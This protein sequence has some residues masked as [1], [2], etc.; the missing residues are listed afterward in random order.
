MRTLLD[1]IPPHLLDEALE[2]LTPRTA[3]L[4]DSE[5]LEE[6][7]EIMVICIVI[8]LKRYHCGGLEIEGLS[9]ETFNIGMEL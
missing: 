1:E 5:K 8:Q 6:V 3:S 2:T 9:I 4:P 7:L